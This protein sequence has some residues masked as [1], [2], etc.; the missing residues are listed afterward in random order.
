[1]EEEDQILYLLHLSLVLLLREKKR[2][3]RKAQRRR[4]RRFGVRPILLGR[5]EHGTFENLL[6]EARLSDPYIF[7]NFTRMSPVAFD[8]LLEIVGPS[9][10]KHSRREPISPGCRSVHHYIFCI[11]SSIL[12]FCKYIHIKNN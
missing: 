3:G 8:Q 6:K 2:L 12:N 1:M 5:K 10:V 7:F 11:D 9:L 4:P